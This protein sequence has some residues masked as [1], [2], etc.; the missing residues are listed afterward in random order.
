MSTPSA[1][2]NP[3][4]PYY[5]GLTLGNFGFKRLR[6]LI[7]GLMGYGAVVALSF[8]II[9][10]TERSFSRYEPE[11]YYPAEYVEYYSVPTS[12][13]S[14]QPLPMPQP[15][16][17]EYEEPA[18]RIVTLASEYYIADRGYDYTIFVEFN[19]QLLSFHVAHDVDINYAMVTVENIVEIFDLLYESFPGWPFFDYFIRPEPGNILNRQIYY[20][21]AQPGLVTYL[22]FSQA[23]G[24]PLPWWL[25]IGLEAY[26]MG[27]EDVSF[28]DDEYLAL[29]LQPS[30][31][32]VPFGDGWFVPSLAPNN[33]QIHDIAYTIVRTWS[34]AQDLYDTI[35]FAQSDTHAFAISLNQHI[36]DLT[37]L[38]S[39][40]PVQFLYQFGDL[41]VVTPQ[42]G[43]I[44]VYD[45][46][47][48]NW[49]RIYSFVQYMEA[50]IEF[51]RNHFHI[52]NTERIKVTLYPFGV[53]NVPD[54]IAHLAYIFGWDAPDVN[55]VTNDEIILAST[56]R[57]GTW[58]IAHEVTHIKLFR[59]LPAYRPAT[60]MVEGMAVLGEILFRN[61]FDGVRTYRFS[62][63]TVENINALARNSSGHILPLNDDDYMFGRDVWTYDEAGSFLFY[64]YNR[65]GMEPLLAFYLS[66]N[67]NQF[68]MAYELFG[69]DLN[70]LM[71]SWRGYLWPSGE[72]ED[73]W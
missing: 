22:Y 23:L 43:Y 1:G 45:N 17:I 59:E 61:A 73:W 58:A 60:W 36:A 63:P 52:T 2:D 50:S 16:P 47:D 41:K 24:Y 66:N 20:N 27:C 56:S 15:P 25:C 4:R 21:F 3:N 44:F 13:P 28:L 5:G 7:L 70:D 71:A 67:D 6:K 49:A 31:A 37:G 39:P 35:R 57:L 26:L 68:E 62:V 69:E 65:F 29:A 18:P 55:F 48:W 38:D 14:P 34:E 30:T 54:S 11:V 12:A 9:S 40:A 51:I 72:P 42:G 53:V 32:G 19:E 33:P 46:Y 10:G 8:I 64:M